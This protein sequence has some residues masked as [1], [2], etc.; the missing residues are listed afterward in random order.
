MVAINVL[1][2]HGEFIVNKMRLDGILFPRKT[3][4]EPEEIDTVRNLGSSRGAEC[5]ICDRVSIY[6]KSATS[7]TLR[8][9]L[10]AVDGTERRFCDSLY[11]DE[12]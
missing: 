10:I 4:Q 12:S 5:C 8:N 7:A 2:S 11:G 6:Q 9:R 3:E 1:F